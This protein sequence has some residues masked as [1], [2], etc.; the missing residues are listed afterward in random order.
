MKGTETS[1]RHVGEPKMD[2]AKNASASAVAQWA[3]QSPLSGT[4]IYQM[5]GILHNI[6][7]AACEMQTLHFNAGST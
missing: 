5:S 1:A 2:G 7:K 6:I 3:Q 4:Q